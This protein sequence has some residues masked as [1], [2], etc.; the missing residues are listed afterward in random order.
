MPDDAG[1]T[2][3]TFGDLI[4]QLPLDLTLEPQWGEEDF[5][6]GPSNADAFAMI[7]RWPDWPGRVLLLRGPA[8]AG[9]THLA[10]IWCARSGATWRAASGLTAGDIPALAE[11][12]AAIDGIQPGFDET[13]LF[14]LVNLAAERGSDLLLTAGDSLLDWRP[15]LP[16]LA[17]RLRRS[18]LVTIFEPDDTLIRALLVK[19]FLDRQLRIDTALVD[20]SAVRLERSFE[21]VRRFVAIMDRMSLA[22]NRRP[23]TRLAARALDWMGATDPA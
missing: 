4:R 12:G 7:G 16:D 9:K 1:D 23:T 15:T 14:H 20:Y 13:I 2:D 6:V 18:Q 8:G 17:S 22:M 11:S 21:A 19:L 5:L 10:R 3:G